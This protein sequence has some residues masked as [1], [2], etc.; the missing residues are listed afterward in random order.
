M[1]S[2]ESTCRICGIIPHIQAISRKRPYKTKLCAK[3][4]PNS[5]P[6]VVPYHHEVSKSHFRKLLPSRISYTSINSLFSSASSSSSSSHTVFLDR[7]PSFLSGSPISLTS[8][9]R[10]HINFRACLISSTRLVKQNTNA[11]NIPCSGNTVAAAKLSAKFTPPSLL[12]VTTPY[13]RF[14]VDGTHT[15]SIATYSRNATRAYVRAP[16][17]VRASEDEG[18][19]LPRRDGVRV[20]LA[21]EMRRGNPRL[22][23][24]FPRGDK[25]LYAGGGVARLL[26]RDDV[27]DRVVERRTWDF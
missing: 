7:I 9:F 1:I 10:H 19:I 6:E 18:I 17:F 24:L 15:I 5:P 21:V 2:A 27:T 8:N 13:T 25:L 3:T 4:Y 22:E 26:A 11:L 16:R 23:L 12:A 20:N 14:T